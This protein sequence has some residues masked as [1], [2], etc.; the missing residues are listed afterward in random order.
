VL[1]GPRFCDRSVAQIRATLLDEG[2]YLASMSTMHTLL[3]LIGQ[4]GDHR[5]RPFTP[6]GRGRS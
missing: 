3:R 5:D 4:S 1:T 6:P 2:V